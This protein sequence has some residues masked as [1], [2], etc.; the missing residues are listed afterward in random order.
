MPPYAPSQACESLGRHRD[1]GGP[2]QHWHSNLVHECTKLH[3]SPARVRVGAD[4]ATAE[5]PYHT[6]KQQV[7]GANGPAQGLPGEWVNYRTAQPIL[8][9]LPS[10]Q[11]EWIGDNY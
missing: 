1:R 10:K 8:R 3:L 11:A 2:L 7:V 6:G 9:W 5:A 4:I